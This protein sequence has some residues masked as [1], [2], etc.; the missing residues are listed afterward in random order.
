MAGPPQP[1]KQGRTHFPRGEDRHLLIR[2]RVILPPHRR[3][4]RRLLFF[5]YGLL[6]GR[7]QDYHLFPSS[8]AIA[9]F[10]ARRAIHWYTL[11]S[12]IFFRDTIFAQ[13]LYGRTFGRRD[14]MYFSMCKANKRNIKQRFD[15]NVTLKN[16]VRSC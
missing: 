15:G 6:L 5:H 16:N 11:R 13:N 8:E 12:D 1:V 7:R 9:G 4:E 3:Q 10:F 2:S 14:I